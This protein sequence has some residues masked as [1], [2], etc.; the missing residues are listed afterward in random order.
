MH[1]TLFSSITT[2]LLLL[3]SQSTFAAP[4]PQQGQSEDT[5]ATVP[6]ISQ[7]PDGQIQAA[8]TTSSDGTSSYENPFTSYTSMTNSLG[9]V[10]GM[11]SV[12]TSQPSVVTSQPE[13]V[14]SQPVSPTLPSYSGFATTGTTTQS[15]TGSASASGSS[16]TVQTES[17]SSSP[18]TLATSS[19]PG[20]S[21]GSGTASASAT[22]AQATGAAVPVVANKVGGV[23]ITLFVLGMGFSLL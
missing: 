4:G 5:T 21:S 22:I 20:S 14:T 13:V 23:G 3:Q 10:T 15:A 18:T 1:P 9:V 7:I 11:P 6:A 16:N 12:V 19:K 17:S 2:I 8:A